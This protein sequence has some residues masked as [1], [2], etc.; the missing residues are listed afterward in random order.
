MCVCNDI[1]NVSTISL[2]HYMCCVVIIMHVYWPGYNHTSSTN[3][4]IVATT[5][6]SPEDLSGVTPMDT[7][8]GTVQWTSEPRNDT[9][10]S[11]QSNWADF[12]S[13]TTQRSPE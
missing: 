4:Y 11:P 13:F 8:A 2:V 3:D 10:P 12:S 7:G 9:P 6:Q 5:W 1:Q